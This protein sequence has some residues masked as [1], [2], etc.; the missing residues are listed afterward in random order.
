MEILR[1]LLDSSGEDWLDAVQWL[2]WTVLGGLLPIWGT[3]LLLL[4]FGQQVQLQS[5]MQN[6]EF[7]LYSASFF[8][9][10]LYLIMRDFRTRL[11]PSRGLI[12]FTAVSLLLLSALI[13][14]GVTVNAMSGNLPFRV[15]GRFLEVMSYFLLAVSCIVGFLATVAGNAQTPPDIAGVKDA[16][17]AR[18]SR[19]F[20]KLGG[21]DE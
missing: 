17:L 16:Q 9:G 5:L 10:A 14:S 13:F 12:G 4:L 11:F 7:V 2:L 15:D 6:G 1:V 18:L 21:D 20:D 3:V 19:E 8:G